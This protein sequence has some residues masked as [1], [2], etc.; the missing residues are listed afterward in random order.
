MCDICSTHKWTR[1]TLV[2]AP[3]T[4]LRRLVTLAMPEKGAEEHKEQTKEWRVFFINDTNNDAARRNNDDINDN[5]ELTM[6]RENIDLTVNYVYIEQWPRFL[7]RKPQEMNGMHST[8]A[9]THNAHKSREPRAVSYKIVEWR[10]GIST[11]C[12]IVIGGGQGTGLCSMQRARWTK[13]HSH[14]ALLWHCCRRRRCLLLTI[15]KHFQSE[16]NTQ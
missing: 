5:K 16:P 13:W 2:V 11:V 3:K 14:F 1:K 9:Y 7:E 6:T 15:V 4:V 12:D 10:K 8:M